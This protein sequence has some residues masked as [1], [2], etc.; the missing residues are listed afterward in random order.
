MND[1]REAQ[2]KETAMKKISTVQGFKGEIFE[3]QK[4]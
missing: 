3:G 2:E 1:V 4:L